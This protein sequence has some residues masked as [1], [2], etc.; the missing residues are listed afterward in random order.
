MPAV[1]Q[2]NPQVSMD[3]PNMSTPA[4]Q[5]IPE[6]AFGENKAAALSQAGESLERVSNALL[7]H[8]VYREHIQQRADV[9]E[10]YSQYSQDMNNFLY[11]PTETQVDGPSNNPNNPTQKIT[12]TTGLMQRQGIAAQN[13]TEAYRTFQTAQAQKYLDNAGSPFQREMLQRL[14]DNHDDSTFRNVAKYESQQVQKHIQGTADDA[15]GNVMDQAYKA[16]SADDV[17]K[18]VESSLP[19]VGPLYADTKGLTLNA[20]RQS[21]YNQAAENAVNGNIETN[22]MQAQKIVSD[23][24]AKGL[25]DNATQVKLN[26]QLDGKLLADHAD[27]VW[28]TDAPQFR[29]ADGSYDTEGFQKLVDGM[30]IPQAQKNVIFDKVKA[31]MSASEANQK[32]AQANDTYTAW[33]Q[34]A[35]MKQ[36]GASLDDV[37]AKIIGTHTGFGAEHQAQL[38]A[39]VNKMFKQESID[40]TVPLADAVQHTKDGTYGLQDIQNLRDQLTDKHYEQLLGVYNNRLMKPESAFPTTVKDQLTAL[41][42]KNIPN[43]QD[44]TV[45]KASLNNHF[46]QVG[47][48][49]DDY[50]N[51]AN[52]ELKKYPAQ[53]WLGIIPH[54]EPG[55]KM[56]QPQPGTPEADA[57][58]LLK[59]R[60][61]PITAENISKIIPLLGKQPAPKP[62]TQSAAQ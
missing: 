19:T 2:Y 9:A 48:T 43:K 46:L 60:N 53:K 49:S 59:S 29:R 62:N 17:V 33:N 3:V 31:N 47:G 36:Q 25:I 27:A 56:E 24:A 18:G 11:N 1:P 26:K 52:D 54:S 13:N 39:D 21:A 40:D 38:E 14:I 37:K 8:Q 23:L 22:P 16:Q 10:Q 4:L 28:K 45:F 34:A 20:V 6:A 57:V 5:P 44:Q 58:A 7:S 50:L 12:T 41:I 32:Q 51:M 42:N 61:K 35:A 15:Y 30:D 55:Y